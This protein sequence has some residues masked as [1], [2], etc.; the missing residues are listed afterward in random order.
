[1]RIRT[2]SRI[3]L[4]DRPADRAGPSTKSA[5]SLGATALRARLFDND[6]AA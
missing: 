2:P 3:V 6:G 1:M 5:H 4:C